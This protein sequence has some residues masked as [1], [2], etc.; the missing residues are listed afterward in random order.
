MVA[1]LT[2]S[3]RRAASLPNSPTSEGERQASRF[4]LAIGAVGVV[5]ALAVVLSRHVVDI[6]AVSLVATLVGW[7]TASALTLHVI[8]MDLYRPWLSYVS[9]GADIAFS[10]VLPFALMTAMDHNFTSGILSGVFFLVITLAAV[11]RGPTLVVIV[12]VSAALAYLLITGFLLAGFMPR[13]SHYVLHDQNVFLGVN[14]IDQLGKALG[15]VIAGWLVAYVARGLRNSER[16]YQELFE[17]IPDGIVITRSNGTIATVNS[18]F[19]A[20]LGVAAPALVDT[21]LSEL[22]DSIPVDSAIGRPTALVEPPL[23]LKRHDGSRIPVRVATSPIDLT[24][25]A[26][27]VMSVRDVTD[28]TQLE[29]ALAS[30]RKIETI[31][32]LAG[33]LAHDFNNILGGIL[34]AASVGTRVAGRAPGGERNKL[35]R[36][37][38]MI[39][40]GGRSARDVVRKLLDFTRTSP[41]ETRRFSLSQV[42]SDVATLCRKT[43]GSAIEMTAVCAAVDEPY[44]DGDEGALKQALLSLCLNAGDSMP[45]GGRIALRAEE[46]P[47]SRSFYA[48]HPE[49]IPGRR[50]LCAAVEDDGPG[51]DPSALEDIFAPRFVARPQAIG[52]ELRLSTIYKLAHQH[53]G[54]I[55]VSSAPKTG[56]S[57]R[58][59]LPRAVTTPAAPAHPAQEELAS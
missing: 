42:L 13:T 37:F 9:A 50:Y 15:M 45:G 47:S 31:G 21:R 6:A 26:G 46:A 20:M 36:Q 43:F 32:R 14:F 30:S 27:A 33:G 2:Y 41:L 8:R 35:G 58:L 10:S 54:F 39:E 23:T 11:R 59:Y 4:R 40:E 18:R 1:N 24:E 17:A 28:N 48:C 38:A 19:A 22:L 49:A 5:I 51:I 3:A 29:H 57:L 56:T 16:H 52:L 53:R 7:S 44:V 25:G 12:A 34:G 55:E